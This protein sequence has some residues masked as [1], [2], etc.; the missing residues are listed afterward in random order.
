M[1]EILVIGDTHIPKRAQR[2]PPLIKKELDIL[3]TNELFNFVI[4]TGDLVKSPETLNYL[5]N[6]AKER[7]LIVEGN[8]DYFY[9]NINTP[10]YENLAIKLNNNSMINFGITHGAEIYPRG[11]KDELIKIAKK[12]HVN[13]LI[14]GHTHFQ[15]TFLSKNGILLLNPGSSTGAWSFVG[16][17]IPSFITI[18]ID[19]MTKEI[20]IVLKE[21]KNN[22]INEKIQTYSF[23]NHRLVKR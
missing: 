8:M 10:L 19:I 3:T 23:E 7:F 5:K 4:F 17:R 20:K 16:S 21:L 12:N 1:V 11:N 15:E 14:Y 2:F 9:G 18:K 22:V 6:L 13:I